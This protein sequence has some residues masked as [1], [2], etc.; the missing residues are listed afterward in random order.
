MQNGVA[1]FMGMNG[2]A[3]LP[4][5]VNGKVTWPHLGTV[6][7]FQVQVSTDLANWTAADPAAVDSVTDPARV[8][9]ILPVGAARTFCRLS[10]TP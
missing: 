9:F 8:V 4:G 6:T 3:T 1:Y 5:V 7:A 2:L 10:V